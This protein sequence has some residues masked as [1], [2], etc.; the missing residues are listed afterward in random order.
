MVTGALGVKEFRLEA[1][2]ALLKRW[3]SHLWS[4]CPPSVRWPRRAACSRGTIRALS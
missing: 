4:M 1:T 3:R 2:K